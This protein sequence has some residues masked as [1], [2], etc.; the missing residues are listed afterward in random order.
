MKNEKHVSLRISPELLADFTYVA[1]YD[2]RSLNWM[3]LSMIRNCISEFE[4]EHGEIPRN[5]E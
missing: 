5:K 1:K 2:D 3:L 4:K